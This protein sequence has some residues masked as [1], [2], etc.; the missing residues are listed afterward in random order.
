MVT[1]G[2]A[3]II[4]G[5]LLVLTIIGAGLGILCIFIGL[6]FIIAGRSGQKTIVI[7]TTKEDGTQVVESKQ[8]DEPTFLKIGWELLTGLLGIVFLLYIILTNGH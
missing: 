1:F 5:C 7:V 2:K 6:I 4:I 8:P 3:L